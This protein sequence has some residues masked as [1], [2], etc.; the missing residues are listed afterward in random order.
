M[1]T[2]TLRPNRLRTHFLAP[3]RAAIMMAVSPF[4]SAALSNLVTSSGIQ[5]SESLLMMQSRYHLAQTYLFELLVV[6]AM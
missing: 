3:F 2:V 1:S 6:A 4:W 5:V